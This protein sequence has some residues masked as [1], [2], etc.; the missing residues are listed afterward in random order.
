[1]D[2]QTHLAYRAVKLSLDLL[3]M[4]DL[5]AGITGK[6]GSVKSE[7]RGEPV[8]LHRGDQA[9]VVRWLAGHLMP[10]NRGFPSRID[11]GRLW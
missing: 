7:N 3:R 9:G 4:D 11:R 2:G 10:D 8:H 6:A 5:D 1:M